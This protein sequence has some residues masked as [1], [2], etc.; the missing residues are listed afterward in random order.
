MAKVTVVTKWKADTNESMRLIGVFSDHQQAIGYCEK[1]DPEHK[2]TS[3]EGLYADEYE[4]DALVD[5][6]FKRELMP[7]HPCRR[8][9]DR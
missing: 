4:I 2:A 8:G 9:G 7:G 1:H 5:D 3:P 6:E